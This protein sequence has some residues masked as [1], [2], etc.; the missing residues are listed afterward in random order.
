MHANQRLKAIIEAGIASIFS[1]RP[2][3]KVVFK[4]VAVRLAAGK[5]IKMVEPTIPLNTRPNTDPCSQYS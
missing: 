2:D 1:P 3:V 4:D 5:F